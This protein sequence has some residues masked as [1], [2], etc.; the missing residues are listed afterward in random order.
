MT[1]PAHSVLILFQ[2]RH[3]TSK[4]T[5]KQVRKRRSVVFY[6]LYWMDIGTGKAARVTYAPGADVLPVFSPDCLKVMW[7]STRDGRSPSQ[8]YIADFTPPKE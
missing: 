4:D 5:R 7:T 8:L 3:A 2:A 1:F 6:D